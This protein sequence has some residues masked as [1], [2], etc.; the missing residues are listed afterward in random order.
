MMRKTFISN[1]LM[2]SS[3]D[4]RKLAAKNV[5][6]TSRKVDGEKILVQKLS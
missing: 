1:G 3:K 4:V 6:G 2:K 5:D